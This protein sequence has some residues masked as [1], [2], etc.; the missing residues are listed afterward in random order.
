M[1]EFDWQQW[2][3]EQQQRQREQ[4]ERLELE[5][6]EDLQRERQIE[7][8]AAQSRDAPAS[9]ARWWQRLGFGSRKGSPG[10][11]QPGAGRRR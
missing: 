8:Q 2:Q 3:A 5:R 1:S 6:E 11:R 9:K 7:E 4:D 10:P